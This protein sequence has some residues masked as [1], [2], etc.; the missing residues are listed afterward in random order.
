MRTRSALARVSLAA[1]VALLA[2]PPAPAAAQQAL[3]LDAAARPD[4]TLSLVAAPNPVP[5]GGTVTYTLTVR[6][7]RPG[8][9]TT[10]S[11]L[12]AAGGAPTQAAADVRVV[13]HLP[14]GITFRSASGDSGFACTFAA[15][16]VTCTGGTVAPDGAATITV[17]A[18]AHPFSLPRVSTASADPLNALA[19]R[20]ETNNGASVSVAIGLP[21]LLV[22]GVEYA[23]RPHCVVPGPDGC[24]AAAGWDLVR[25]VTVRNAGLA[26]A[27]DV[28][29]DVEA[30]W[31]YYPGAWVGIAAPDGFSCVTTSSS[32]Y[33]HAWRCTGGGVPPGGAVAFK[34][35]H[36][37]PPIAGIVTDVAL[38]PAGAILESNESNNFTRAICS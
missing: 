31:D 22:A 23:T 12:T 19:E 8:T 32:D 14:A 35:S 36:R 13:Q 24:L 7:R 38:D 11:G 34:V 17:A 10:T 27:T 30:G 1:A 5:A 2:A 4:L 16:T 20:D 26:D 9:V 28:R 25:T 3:S 18:T 6:N 29:L 15:P 37:T 33:D 21:D